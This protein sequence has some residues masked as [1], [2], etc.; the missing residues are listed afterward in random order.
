MNET[1]PQFTYPSRLPVILRTLLARYSSNQNF[2]TLKTVVE[3]AKPNLELDIDYNGEICFHRLVLFVSF[4]TYMLVGTSSRTIEN[5]IR[6]DINEIGQIS[7]EEIG[8][9][10][11]LVEEN[12]SPLESSE[13]DSTMWERGFR[14]F[15]SHKVEDK[16]KAT[17]LKNSL[18][19]YGITAFVAHEDIETNKEWLATI[20]S[21]LL[22]MDAFV[23]LITKGYNDKFWTQ[24]E[25]GFAYCMNKLRDI[26][27][28]SIRIGDDP[29]GFFGQMQAFSPHSDDYAE[30]LCEQWIDHPRMI[31]SLIIALKKSGC[32]TNSARYFELLKKTSNITERQVKNLIAAYNEN[33]SVNRCFKMNGHSGSV[34][35]LINGR[36]GQKYE[37]VRVGA[38]TKIVE[39]NEAPF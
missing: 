6:N 16:L 35:N 9:V 26:P 39:K 14:V 34:L 20:E 30:A 28:V 2:S 38:C 18:A 29:K 31:D 5:R 4:E 24:Q 15:I 19:K 22:T 32:F 13:I 8:C 7:G 17:E 12:V 25:V 23:A 10:S 21:A 11:I 33:E 3:K 1:G 36:T 37:I 27:F